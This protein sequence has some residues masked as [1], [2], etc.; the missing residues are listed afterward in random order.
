MHKWVVQGEEFTDSYRAAEAVL[1]IAGDE[2]YE[3]ILYECYGDDVS[4][5]GMHYD[6]VYVLR[7]IDPIAYRVGKADALDS[8]M[9]DVTDDLERMDEINDTTKIYG[10]EVNYYYDEEEDQERIKEAAD[11]LGWTATFHVDGDDHKTV[12]FSACSP[13]GEDLE[14]EIEYSDI[15]DI[16][17]EMSSVAS[18][19]DP[20]EHVEMW[21]MARHDGVSGV[22]SASELVEDANEIANMLVKLADA[23]KEVLL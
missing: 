19:F 10:V 23:L 7:E 4:I 9:S 18:D 11:E 14:E 20:D 1:D 6:P 13:A 12:I 5:C 8:Y 16:Y 2:L 21:I 15:T 22:H 17:W 3:Q